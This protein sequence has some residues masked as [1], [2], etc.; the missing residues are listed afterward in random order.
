MLKFLLLIF[1]VLCSE[2]FEG[3]EGNLKRTVVNHSICTDKNN[4][5]HHCISRLFSLLRLWDY[6]NP[7]SDRINQECQVCN[8]NVQFNIYKS[9]DK[10]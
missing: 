2:P 9:T 7:N 1:S 10:C 6:E 3:A 4:S 8:C 5:V